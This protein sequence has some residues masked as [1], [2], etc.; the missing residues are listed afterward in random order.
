MIGWLWVGCGEPEATPGGAPTYYQDVAPVL[1][2][3]CGACHVDGGGAPFSVQDYPTAA[4]W[5]EVMVD[6]VE[7]GRMPPYFAEETDECE[8]RVGLRDDPRMT[9]DEEA[10]LAAWAAAGA[11][12]GDPDAAAPAPVRPIDHLDAPDV[13][14]TMTEPF[15]VS[16]DRDIYQCL[17]LALPPMDGDRWITGLEVLPDNDKVVHHVL[18]WNDPT[19]QSAVLGGGD[20]SYACSGFPGVWPTEIAGI[21]TPGADPTRA[22]LGAGTLVHP[23]ASLVLNIHYHPTGTT[24]ETDR[25]QVA[26][27]WTDTAPGQSATWFLVDLPF[28]AQTEP[29]PHDRSDSAEFRIP[30]GEP[31]HRETVALTIPDLIGLD[32]PIFA[33]TPHMHYLGSEML[34]T[35]DHPD[36]SS[37]CLIHT[38]QY[39]FDYQT[40]Y[41][42]DAQQ[43]DL[44]TARVGDTVRVRCTYDNSADSR[45]MS[46][47]LAASGGAAPQDV[48]WGE[49]TEDEMCMAMV[50][51]VLPP[52]DWLSLLGGLF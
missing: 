24:T 47:Y 17:R 12:E 30:A 6:A 43:A 42:Y 28:G 38:P 39:R 41:T 50:G 20:D 22:P 35:L 44:H 26:I 14:L 2:R 49:Q 40:M 10:L 8:M 23:G 46:D 16:G 19:D 9:E 13:T 29:G 33:I 7:S 31:S 48:Y 45:F 15:E 25:T 27:E 21:W 37:D 1:A 34:V 3:R 4:A 11:P 52:G 5:A 51:L 36:G 18:V 32:L